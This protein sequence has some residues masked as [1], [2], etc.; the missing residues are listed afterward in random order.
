MNVRCLD[1]VQVPV[2]HFRHGRARH[3]GAFLGHARGVQVTAGVFRIAQVHIGDD[4][5]DAAVRLFGQAFVKA[6]V[7]GLHVEDGD[8]QA[9]GPYHAQAGVG[10]AQ[11]QH[12]IGLHLHHQL[13]ALVDDVAHR[14]AQVVAHRVQVDIRVSQLQV[15]EE[16]A[17]QVVVIV[18]P[19]MR[20]QAVKIGAALVY[21]RR[22]ADDFRAGAHDD[23]QFQAAVVPELDVR[24][25]G[26]WLH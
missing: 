5:H 11:H 17:V 8:V 16:H 18:L 9:L 6:A 13:V 24:I 22:Q 25:I 10:V 2:Q 26:Y 14:G 12:G 15:L 19:R 4:V 7:A 3:V 23:Q 1:A 21:H 20:Q